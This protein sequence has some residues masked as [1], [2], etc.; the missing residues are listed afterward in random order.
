MRQVNLYDA[1]THLSQLVDEAAR[2]EEIVIAKNG[3]P[4]A[5]LVPL[6]AAPKRYLR[7]TWAGKI[8]LPEDFDAPDDEIR[9]LFEGTDE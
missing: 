7:G 8:D 9:R 5:R 4:A 2:G 3:R 1:K 6:A